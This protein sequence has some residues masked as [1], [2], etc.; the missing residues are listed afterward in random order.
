ME[1]SEKNGEGRGGEGRGSNEVAHLNNNSKVNSK[2]IFNFFYDKM[3]SSRSF[4]DQ[5]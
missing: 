5:K 4:S 1:A 2:V 3:C